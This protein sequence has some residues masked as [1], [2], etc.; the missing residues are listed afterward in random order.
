M[1]VE[2][3]EPLVREILSAHHSA[4]DRLVP[5]LLDIQSRIGYLPE[6]GMP[7]VAEFLG[8][9]VGQIYSVA[10]FYS[11]FRLTPVGKYHIRVCRGTACHIRGAPRVVEALEAA[12]G[13]TEGETSPDLRYTLETVACIGCCALA[14]AM[15]INEDVH[16][17]MTPARVAA[18]VAGLPEEETDAR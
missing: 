3:R 16:G 10:S 11:Q 15:K 14:P 5:I 6:E 1:E 17:E 9:T 18:V 4:P 7:A 2:S 12:T 13:I 8:I